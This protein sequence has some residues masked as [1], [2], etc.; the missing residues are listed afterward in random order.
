MRPNP[1]NFVGC[2][3]CGQTALLQRNFNMI[4]PSTALPLKKCGLTARSTSHKVCGI[5]THL[6]IIL[7]ELNLKYSGIGISVT[8]GHFFKELIGKAIW[9]QK[10]VNSALIFQLLG[11]AEVCKFLVPYGFAK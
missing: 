4:P 5:W 8:K 7:I 1:T 3:S 11:R 2:E 10:F 9:Y 6:Y